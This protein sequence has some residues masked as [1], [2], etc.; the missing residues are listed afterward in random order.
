MF[1]TIYELI[2]NIYQ[3]F[4]F[5]WFI[6]N[7][8][9]EKRKGESVAFWCC[10]LLTSA[11]LS[12]YLIF[13]LPVW[14]T[15][16][17]IFI[18]V[19]TLVF[20][21]DSILK[22]LYWFMILLIISLGTIGVF[23]HLVSFF[24]KENVASLSGSTFQRLSFTLAVNALIAIFFFLIIKVFRKKTAQPQNFSVLLIVGI[25]CASLAD[26]FYVLKDIYDISGKLLFNGCGLTL[27]IGGL[28][29]YIYYVMCDYS[30]IIQNYQ[31]KEQMLEVQQNQIEEL[32]TMYSSMLK[33][34]HDINA[35]IHDLQELSSS[36]PDAYLNLLESRLHP[37]PSTGN[38]A[39][40]SV[41]SAKYYKMEANQIEFRG[42]NLH[43][44]GGM[45]ITDITL[46]SLISNMLDN[47]I[48]ALLQAGEQIQ[49]PYIYLGFSYSAAGLMII[50]E[51]PIVQKKSR[52]SFFRS[53]K[54]EPGHGLGIT[55]MQKIAEDAKGQIDF[56]CADNSFKVLALIPPARKVKQNN[57]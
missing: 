25:L 3:G 32:Q 50:C 7:I 27:I 15:W 36:N 20:F 24:L 31:I 17:L 1:W 4:L 35:Y 57:R 48:E 29:L 11:A 51:N 21:K 6:H 5:T 53:I 52:A 47:A 28:T 55:I 42:T 23:Y 49:T 46:C 22:K 2:L 9:T 40:D 12:S 44:T 26:L 16:T 19:Y 39:L 8:L 33:Q 38:S 14:D 56:I 34:Q 43:Y 45:N 13:P 37:I 30:T 18:F 10:S 54:K 41:L